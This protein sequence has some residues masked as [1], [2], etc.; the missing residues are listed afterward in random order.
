METAAIND[1]TD[2]LRGHDERL[3][4]HSIRLALLEKSNETIS[5]GLDSIND[6]VWKLIWIVVAGFAAAIVGFI[7]NG[8]LSVGG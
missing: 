6:G 7:I 8:G 2:Q 5:R 3:N 4:D 1:L